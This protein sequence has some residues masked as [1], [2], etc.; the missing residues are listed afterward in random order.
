[1]HCISV[2]RSLYFRIFPAS[3]F[4]TFVSSNYKIH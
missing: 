1:M 2:V 3:F 4:I